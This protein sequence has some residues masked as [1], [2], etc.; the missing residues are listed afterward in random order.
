MMESL[1]DAEVSC[2]VM[3]LFTPAWGLVAPPYSYR[4]MPGIALH[5][6]GNNGHPLLPQGVTV[7]GG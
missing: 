2:V 4:A 5:H 1:V 6:K 3:I 7:A